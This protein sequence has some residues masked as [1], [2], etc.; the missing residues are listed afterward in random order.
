MKKEFQV[1][2][3]EYVGELK[4]VKEAQEPDYGEVTLRDDGSFVVTKNGLPYHVPNIEGFAD[5]FKAITKYAEKY[6]DKVKPEPPLPPP[7]PPDPFAVMQFEIEEA[8]QQLT[9]TDYKIIKCTEY[10]MEGLDLPYDIH[11]LHETRQALRDKINE[12]E[13]QLKGG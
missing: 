3:P 4:E 5:E 8:K 12:L 7:P 13:E 11:E 2:T 9:D 10:Q 1:I 6:P